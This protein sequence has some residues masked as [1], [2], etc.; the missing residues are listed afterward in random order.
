MNKNLIPVIVGGLLLAFVAFGV[1]YSVGRLAVTNIGENTQT[2]L[3]VVT[4]FGQQMEKVPLLASKEELTSAMQEAYG[5]YV[6]VALI[7]KWLDVPASAPGRKT[8]SPWP[9]RIDVSDVVPNDDGSY[10]VK[11]NVVEVTSA[12]AT[13]QDATMYPVSLTL[14]QRNDKWIITTFDMVE[15]APATST[16]TR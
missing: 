5:P 2:V 3:S 13:N 14:I 11:G 6:D 10:T 9:A 8:S 4:T 15:P 1:W 7:S 12:E 16:Q